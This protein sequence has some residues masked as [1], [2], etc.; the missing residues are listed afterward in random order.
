MLTRSECFYKELI[1]CLVRSDCYDSRLQ[2]KN[3]LNCSYVASVRTG[4]CQARAC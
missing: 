2:L 3:S 4:M 1:Y